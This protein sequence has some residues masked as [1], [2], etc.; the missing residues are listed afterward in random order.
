[1]SA[2]PPFFPF[3][4]KGPSSRVGRHSLAM[5]KR[6]LLVFLLLA[7]AGCTRPGRDQS[8]SEGIS[9][10]L[11]GTWI[12]TG[13]AGGP[14]SKQ[15]SGRMKFYTGH[16]WIITQADPKS[17]EVIFL[18]GGTYSIEGDIL[19]QTVEYAKDNTLNLVGQSHRFRTSISGDT[20]TQIGVGNRWNET[21][22]RL[23]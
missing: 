14:V 22:S 2:R 19:V 3:T 8:A 20:L 10:E 21:W 15:E 11:V 5:I 13:T 6:T 4:G 23:K 18:H 17:A 7:V 16:H 9:R 1:M 12:L